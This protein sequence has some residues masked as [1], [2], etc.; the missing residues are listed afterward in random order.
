MLN[1]KKEKKNDLMFRLVIIFLINSTHL[2][3]TT[4]DGIKVKN[5]IINFIGRNIHWTLRSTI[6]FQ[7]RKGI[8]FSPC[9]RKGYRINVGA[10]E[11]PIYG[12]THSSS[13]YDSSGTRRFAASCLALREFAA[14]HFPGADRGTE[15]CQYP[16]CSPREQAA[17]SFWLWIELASLPHVAR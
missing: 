8:S 7:Q 12:M 10:K 4:S 15:D 16:M 5:L 11:K 3:I 14:N 1:L 17:F 9:E 6:F 2:Q 13:A